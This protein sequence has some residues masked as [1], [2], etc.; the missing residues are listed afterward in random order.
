[1]AGITGK[2][3][4]LYTAEQRRRRDRSRWTLIQGVLAPLQFLVMLASAF[5][6]VQTLRTGNGYAVATASVL[7]KTG[8]LYLIMVTG[9]LWERD[10]FG[11]YL[12]AEPFFWEDVV[13]MGVIALHTAYL[14]GLLAGWMSREALLGLALVAYGAYG[15]NAIQFLLKLRAARREGVTPAPGTLGAADGGVA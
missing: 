7:V 12:F 10:V 8:L 5:L 4:P 14:A 9:S 11:Q 13:S 2:G 1:M 15:V 6:I 3:R